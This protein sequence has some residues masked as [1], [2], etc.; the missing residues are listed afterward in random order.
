MSAASKLV[1]RVEVADGRLQFVYYR[2]AA[3]QPISLAYYLLFV[4]THSNTRSLVLVVCLL[5]GALAAQP[6]QAQLGVGVGLNFE[7]L[8]DFET[9]S[10]DAT[11]ENSTG[12][13]VGVFYDLAVGPL[14]LRPGI[15]YRETGSYVVEGQ[16]FDL[17][18]IEIPIDVRFRLFALPFVKP[19]LLA[20]PVIS[21]PQGDE[22]FGDGLEDMALTANVGLGVE[23]SPP[24][25]GFTFMPELR[26]AFGLSSYFSDEEFDLGP[27]TV[28]PEDRPTSTA[29]MLRLNVGF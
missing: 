17:S 3:Y 26:Y 15:F 8:D 23:L 27:V 24:G 7:N 18:L 5:V 2:N 4:M 1:R 9:G 11:Y 25:L 21:L 6:A 16:A 14:A 28:N 19:Y 12:Y 20:A 29:F 10:A 13:H 22:D